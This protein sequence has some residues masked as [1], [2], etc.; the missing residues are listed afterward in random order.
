ML[1]DVAVNGAVN[2]S[3]KV[4]RERGGG[5]GACDRRETTDEV[6]VF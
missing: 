5:R 3:G 4:M 1:I 2:D 6:L